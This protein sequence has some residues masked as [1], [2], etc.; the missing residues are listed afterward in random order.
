MFDEEGRSALGT[1]PHDRYAFLLSEASET[2]VT[3]LII[4]DSFLF[5]FSRPFGSH[6]TFY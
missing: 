2:S 1:D 6:Q 5:I 4:I 3:D